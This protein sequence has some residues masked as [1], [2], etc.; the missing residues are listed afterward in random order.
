MNDLMVATLAPL[1]GMHVNVHV[2]TLGEVCL[3]DPSYFQLEV[4]S[5]VR[6]HNS[7]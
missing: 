7:A 6:V 5:A 3:D 2:D 1:D 4:I